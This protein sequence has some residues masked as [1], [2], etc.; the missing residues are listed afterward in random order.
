MTVAANDTR[1]EFK[2]EGFTFLSTLNVTGTFRYP[3][4]YQP[5]KFL[6]WL[7][8]PSGWAQRNSL[9]RIHSKDDASEFAQILEGAFLSCENPIHMHIY[10]LGKR[11]VII[12][13]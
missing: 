1:Q 10:A 11:Y 13:V 6:K 3:P 9:T 7:F 8:L 5:I 2:T 12:Q 4:N